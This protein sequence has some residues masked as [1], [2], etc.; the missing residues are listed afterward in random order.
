MVFMVETNYFQAHDVDRAL[1]NLTLR[2]GV[3]LNEK[4]H[5]FLLSDIYLDFQFFN[6]ILLLFF[7]LFLSDVMALFIDVMSQRY[8]FGENIKTFQQL[9]YQIIIFALT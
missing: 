6:G 9:E 1:L 8:D 5:E 3:G 4:I 2:K 7:T